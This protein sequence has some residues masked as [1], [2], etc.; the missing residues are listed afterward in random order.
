MSL[1]IIETKLIMPTLP[2]GHL[3]RPRIEDS[4]VGRPGIRLVTVMAGA[5]WGKTSALVASL[6]REKRNLLW[7]SLDETDRDPG[8]FMAHLAWAEQSVL[9][10]DQEGVFL[11]GLVNLWR[12]RKQGTVLV[13]DDVQLLG[14]ESKVLDLI[15]RL[16][17]YLPENCTVIL[18]SREPVPL[19]TMKYRNRGAYVSLRAADLKFTGPEIQKLFGMRFPGF[20]LSGDQL[21]S[22]VQHSEGWA[23]GL[24]IFFEILPGPQPDQLDRAVARLGSAGTGWFHYFAEEVVAGLDAQMRDFLHR[25]ALLPRLEAGLCDRV[26][27]R[28]DSLTLLKE[29]SRR[30]LFTFATGQGEGT[31]RYHH[32]F[33]EFLLSGL[34]DQLG[35]SEIEKL[36]VRVGRELSRTGQWAEALGVLSQCRNKGPALTLVGRQAQKLLATGRYADLSRALENLGSRA[37]ASNSEALFLQGSLLD[38]QGRW[39]QAETTYRQ[40]L[41]KG[42]R[43]V[44]RVE[45]QSL[46][47]QL[48]MRAGRYESCLR[49]CRRAEKVVARPGSKVRARL[50]G[51]Q[52][53]SCCAL[54]RLR[55]GESFLNQALRTCRRAGQR[56]GEGRNLFLLA[57]NVHYIRGDFSRAEA[58]AR[59]ALAIFKELGDRRLISHS[60]GVLGFVLVAR[61]RKTEA[62]SFSQDALRRARSLGYRNIEGYCHLNLGECALQADDV[63]SG[64]HHFRAARDIGNEVGEAAL[65]SL[66]LVG[67]A[68]VAL[69]GGNR[70][71]ARRHAASAHE[72]AS[73]CGDLW[74]LAQA[75]MISG[76][77]SGGKAAVAAGHWDEAA[78]LLT[79][80]E[81]RFELA[82]LEL[83]RL[84]A[85]RVPAAKLASRQRAWLT[86]IA[87][88][89]YEFLLTELEPDRARLVLSRLVVSDDGEAELG[90]FVQQLT[91]SLEPVEPLPTAEPTQPL[92]IQAL[93]P[94]LLNL[95]GRTITRR[96]W[97]SSRAWRLFCLLLIRRS[98]WVVRDEILEALWPAADPAKTS[99]NLRQTVHLLRK[100]LV[101]DGPCPYIQFRGDAYSLQCGFEASYDVAE[102]QQALATARSVR[103]QGKDQEADQVLG[104]ALALYRGPLLMEFPY[105]D[106]VQ[107]RREQLQFSHQRAAEQL[108]RSY[109]NMGRWEEALLL[110]R[111]VLVWHPLDDFFHEILVRAQLEMG[112]RREALESYRQYE[113]RLAR[114]LDLLPSSSMRQLAERAACRIRS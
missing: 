21:G 79:R 78:H 41:R 85:N 114:D 51:L 103:R 20:S 29:L 36:R 95:G 52:G 101:P 58:A 84:S 110:C 34:L 77:A 10:T 63:A 67:M 109:R 48:Q 73:A 65:L 28:R 35:D 46:I 100:V 76:L 40:A 54:G 43:P 113:Q 31:Y 106:F 104:Q 3:A 4:W 105:A 57:A 92:Q 75:A 71:A 88:R 24:Q 72:R 81:A 30:N 97:K 93:G 70:P 22:L 47:G 99:N 13:L 26:L 80:L 64:E 9:A 90:D 6:Q 38:F 50:L 8:V 87:E 94:L 7:Y 27:G 82:R 2:P 53:V 111:Q 15:R 62:E 56:S 5:G 96:D 17:Q 98:Q 44:L 108:L 68:K 25:T 19:P 45:L 12:H 49:I 14:T 11:A 66:A 74:P 32:L 69:Q 86:E 23:A 112:H 83:W 33:R 91:K 102:F 89:N 61:G 55:R 37:V 59:Q 107:S 42:P 18:A 16:V 39:E 1:P 60:L